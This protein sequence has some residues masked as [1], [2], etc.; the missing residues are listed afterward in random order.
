MFCPLHL[1]I[2]KMDSLDLSS[3]ITQLFGEDKEFPILPI[4]ANIS[5]PIRHTNSSNRVREK[6]RIDEPLDHMTHLEHSK[7]EELC[8]DFREVQDRLNQ[9]KNFIFPEDKFLRYI[10]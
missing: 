7:F 8:M 9:D 1:V 5:V 2:G 6:M 10:I 3:E 4:M